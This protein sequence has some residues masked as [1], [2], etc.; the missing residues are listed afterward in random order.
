MTK[1]EFKL[2]LEKEIERVESKPASLNDINDSFENRYG[3]I[4]TL[5]HLGLLDGLSGARM[6]GKLEYE[7]SEL[8]REG[9]HGD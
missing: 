5:V 6:I 2:L 9:Y 7:F 4:K 8:E 1:K 3:S